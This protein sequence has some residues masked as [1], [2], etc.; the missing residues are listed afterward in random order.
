MQLLVVV[1]LVLASCGAETDEGLDAE[2]KASPETSTA[3]PSEPPAEPTDKGRN[4]AL[5]LDC[6]GEG[7]S[8][9]SISTK[10]VSIFSLEQDG[11]V[12][13]AVTY[14]S[15]KHGGWLPLQRRVCS[16]SMMPMER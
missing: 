11:R 4:Q 15:D 5:K 16:N 3:T 6:E 10:Q 1:A 7:M 12:V 13:A 14:V 8:I 2:P 9:F